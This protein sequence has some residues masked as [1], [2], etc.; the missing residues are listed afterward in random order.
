MNQCLHDNLHQIQQAERIQ[1]AIVE[2]WLPQTLALFI[3]CE[4]ILNILRFH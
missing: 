2:R 1:K 3:S 4:Y